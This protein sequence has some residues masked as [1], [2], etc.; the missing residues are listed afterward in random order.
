MYRF[1]LKGESIERTKRRMHWRQKRKEKSETK[2]LLIVNE[3]RSI[4]YWIVIQPTK[5]RKY[6]IKAVAHQWYKTFFGGNLNFPK[7][8]KWKKFI[9]MSKPALEWWNNA[10]F[11]ENNTLN[12]FVT[13]KIV[14]FLLFQLRG[15]SRFSRI[16]PKK[17]L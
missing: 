17:F 5:R 14:L 11:K 13:F 10:I 3:I 9:L 1:S 2:D 4:K 6:R 8:K 15:K 12:L 7:I 16:S